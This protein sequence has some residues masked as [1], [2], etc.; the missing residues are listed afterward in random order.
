ML[1]RLRL[2][3]KINM[4][5]SIEVTESFI[6]ANFAAKHANPLV[7]NKISIIRGGGFL[8][9]SAGLGLLAGRMLQVLL[10]MLG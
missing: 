4:V 10:L 1:V 6:V 7:W 3:G 5:G 2:V 9:A 8:G